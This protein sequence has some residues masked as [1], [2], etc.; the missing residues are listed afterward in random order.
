MT[1][2]IACRTGVDKTRHRYRHGIRIGLGNGQSD[3]ARWKKV[4]RRIDSVFSI[5]QGFRGFPSFSPSV[6][7]S[8][9]ALSLS[10]SLARSH[11]HTDTHTH[12]L[13][14]VHTHV[15][16]HTCRQGSKS[17]V[18]CHTLQTW[19][20]GDMCLLF[21]FFIRCAAGDHV[22]EHLLLLGSKS[23]TF[24]AFLPPRLAMCI[25]TSFKSFAII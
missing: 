5:L 3:T 10:L 20:K 22:L 7:A 6:I 4:S 25:Y 23:K 21:S 18:F 24:K 14:H 1:G 17:W 15:R 12:T 16:A 9:T 11:A 8:V 19:L 2:Q 13:T